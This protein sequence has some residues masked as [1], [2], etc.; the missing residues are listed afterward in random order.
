MRYLPLDMANEGM[1]LGKTVYR[2]DDGKVLLSQGTRLKHYYIQRLRL[3]EYTHIYVMDPGDTEEDLKFLEPVREET[4]VQA[5][6]VVRD[7]IRSARQNRPIQMDNIHRVVDEIIDQVLYNNDVVYNIVD[8]KS[9]DNYTYAH[10]VNVC[11]L[12]VLTGKTLGMNLFDLRDLAVGAILHDLGKVY[13]DPDVLN[14]PSELTEDEYAIVKEHPRYGFDALRNKVNLSLLSAHVAFQHHEREDGSGYPRG[15]HSSEIHR[16]AKVVAVADS[17]DA[18]TTARVY[19]EAMMN[20]L[21]IEELVNHT[22][23]YH[24]GVVNSFC[25]AVAIYPIGSVLRLNTRENVVVVNVTK[26]E[27]RVKVL[28]GINAGSY[29]D[30]YHMDEIWVHH[31]I[32]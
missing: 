11:I 7:A 23:K 5:R 15:L 1:R 13:I 14:K 32:S 25:K 17:Y 8:L 21:A 30:L 24:S 18:M 9:H 10:S 26:N 12:S 27:F 29:Y 2:E 6:I 22:D 4:R 31:R 19:K 3:M 20:H 16:F 28:D